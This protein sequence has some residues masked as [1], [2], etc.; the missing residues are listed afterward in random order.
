M[1][2]ATA[3]AC[4]TPAAT[5]TEAGDG[6]D[7]AGGTISLAVVLRFVDIATDA[8]AGAREEID[9]L[10]VYPV[11]DGDTGT[12]MYLTV[13]A[14]RDAIREA[15]GGDPEA[16]MRRGAR[17][18]QPGRAARRPRQLRRD[19][20]RDAAARSRAGSPTPRP[21]SATPS[22]MADA[23]HRGR[24]RELR[25]GRRAG[26]GHHAHR[27]PRRLRGRAR[28]L[29]AERAGARPR[30]VHDRGAGRPR[31]PGPYA[32]AARR[33]SATPA[34][35]TP[36]AAGISVILDAAE[37]VLTGRRPVPVPSPS[38]STRSRSRT[39]PAR[40]EAT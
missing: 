1:A 21:R 13:S 14:A 19:P 18:V 8:L 3:V 7:T 10:N 34:S 37:T 27:L 20:Q 38:A 24:R 9:A 5:T 12:N 4:A 25:R 39:P 23:L 32:G 30:R 28:E 17:R 26:R 29:A 31:G 11:P 35:S 6:R 33:C 15:T 36:A 22:V 16:P 2:P 40:A